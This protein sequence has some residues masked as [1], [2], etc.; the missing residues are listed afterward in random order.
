MVN[1][2]RGE[3]I[4]EDSLINAL[5]NGRL[6]G[7]ALDVLSGENN[8]NSSFKKHALIEY[9]KANNN[10]IITPHIAGMAIEAV[11]DTRLFIVRKIIDNFHKINPK[12]KN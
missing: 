10:L 9:A 8:F 6:S 5:Q 3:L 2:S 7:A 4:D 11:N 1:T 12:E